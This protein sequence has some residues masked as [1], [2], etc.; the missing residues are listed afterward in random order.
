MPR[1]ALLPAGHCTC[2]VFIRINWRLK[3]RRAVIRL[4]RYTRIFFLLENSCR[5]A[6]HRLCVW[7]WLR[8]RFL[9]P[10]VTSLWWW[11]E[12]MRKMKAAWNTTCCLFLSRRW[13]TWWE[14]IQDCA[15]IIFNSAS[16]V[17]SLNRLKNRA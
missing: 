5:Q 2:T 8:A 15:M 3:R 6:R 4:G 7:L 12:L 10:K 17:K 13:I 16:R 11:P 1:D 9:Y 14:Q